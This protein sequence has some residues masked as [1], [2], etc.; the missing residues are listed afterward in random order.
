MT[1]A[2]YQSSPLFFRGGPEKAGGGP[3]KKKK[4][5]HGVPAELE[6]EVVEVGDARTARG[7]YDA[8][9]QRLLGVIR[10]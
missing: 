2:R 3:G 5:D 9:Q 4:K 10:I 7:R 8:V 1:N 6:R